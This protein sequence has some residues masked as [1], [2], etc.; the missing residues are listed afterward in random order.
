MAALMDLL[1]PDVT[2]WSD[3]GGKVTAARRPVVGADNVARWLLGVLAKP[4]TAG[5][6]VDMTSINGSPGLLASFGDEVAGAVDFDVDDGRIVG[7]AA[8]AQPRQA[9]GSAPRR[10]IRTLRW[11]E[12]GHRAQ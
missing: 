6:V 5:L 9:A 4:G 1:A 8:H 11:S 3:G 2:A 7:T 10:M 12:G